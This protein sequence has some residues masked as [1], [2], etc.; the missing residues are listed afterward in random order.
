MLGPAGNG[1]PTLTWA[2]PPLGPLFEGLVCFRVGAGQEPEGRLW[3]WPLLPAS[4]RALHFLAGSWVAVTTATNLCS[5][6]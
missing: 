6:S 2:P 4:I 1:M 3:A 5:L